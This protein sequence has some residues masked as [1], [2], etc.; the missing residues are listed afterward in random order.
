MVGVCACARDGERNNSKRAKVFFSK[1][2]SPDL[3]LRFIVLDASEVPGDSFNPETQRS[4]TNFELRHHRHMI[5]RECIHDPG[6]LRFNSVTLSVEKIIN[7]LHRLVSRIT[8][9]ISL[10][11]A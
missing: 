6:F 9:T 3:S 7:S 11:L 8:K 10:S 4:L 5:R 1:R 2:A